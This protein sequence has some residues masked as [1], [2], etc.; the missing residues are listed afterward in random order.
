MTVKTEGGV[1]GSPAAR[2][3]G[4]GPVRAGTVEQLSRAD[5]V[6]RGK[7]A[8]AVTPLEAHAEFK[9][10][11][12]RDPVGLLLEQAKS[13]VPELV[14]V[15][16]GRMLV[17]SFTF[18]RGAAL[19]MAADLATTPASGL[20]VQLCG[21]AHL[22]NFGAFASPERRLVFDVNDFDE[23][24]PG[25]FEWD[26]KRLAASLAVAGRDN[27]FPAKVRRKIILAAAESYRTA[28]RGFAEQPLMEVWYAHLDIEQAIGRFRSQM[29]AK[30]FKK[31]EKLLA[32]AHTKDST[33]ALAKLTTVADGRRRIIS[34]PPVIVPVEEVYSDVQA[35]AIYEQ[36]RAVLG[37]YRRTLQSDRRHLLEQFTLIQ[38]ARKV[39]GVGSVGTRAWI[40]LMEA[41]DG[42]EPLFLQA[43]EAQPSVLA[44][45]C[46]RSQYTNQGERVVAGQHLMQAESDI[47]LGWTHTPGPDKVDRDFYV[48]QL[49]DWKFSAPIEAMVPSGMAVYAGLCGWALARAHARSGDRIALAAY[50]GG[51][52]SFDQAIAD[53]AETYADQN[54]RDYAALQAAVKDGRAKAASEI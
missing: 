53:F 37:K 9:P 10:T 45:Y 1:P 29:K 21:D 32:K 7:D 13:R 30:R 43:K 36:I 48:R 39:V 3:S 24:L 16:H 26:V 52:G 28:M 2:A 44:E 11:G 40:L 19:P 6:A 51:S 20:R 15:R 27:G 22:S 4:K 33:K 5:R 18:Y 14:P 38:M 47:F 31:A 23:T 42:T 46:G 25:P 17:S 12:P 34:D 50:L 35:A 49:K 8:R 54:E 41:G